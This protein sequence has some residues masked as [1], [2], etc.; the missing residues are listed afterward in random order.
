MDAEEQELLEVAGAIHDDIAVLTARG[1][2]KT[3]VRLRADG[4]SLLVQGL[5]FAQLDSALP[6][7]DLGTD[8][9]AR[10]GR[11]G[12]GATRVRALLREARG[13][14]WR[15]EAIEVVRTSKG[16]A[17]VRLM[18]DDR[19]LET[20]FFEPG[21]PYAVIDARFFEQV[22]RGLPELQARGADL[23]AAIEAGGGVKGW[24]MSQEQR[25]ATLLLDEPMLF[26][27]Q[28]VASYS[29]ESSTFLWAWANRSADAAC[30]SLVTNVHE[31]MRKLDVGAFLKPRMWVE[32]PLAMVLAQLAAWRGGA[33][34]VLPAD[35]GAGIMFLALQ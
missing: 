17:G 22:D 25:T 28:I 30:K 7:P 14:V 35:Q 13:L 34:A 31:K 3:T 27:L 33:R 2:P 29:R 10:M 23:R 21:N 24:R 18:K 19:A 15:G 4:E 6:K 9:A 1:A 12:A 5:S 20:F 11:I 26:P 8:P 16:G 32:P